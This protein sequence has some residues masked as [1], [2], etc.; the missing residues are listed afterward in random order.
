MADR[1]TQL[2]DALD[3]QLTMMYAALNYI[4]TRQPYSDIPGQ[5]NLAPDPAPIPTPDSV[6]APQSAVSQLTNGDASQQQPNGPSQPSQQAVVEEPAADGRPRTPP[7][8]RPE[9][10]NRA[11]REMAQGLVL[12]EQ[13]IEYLINS[14]PGLGNSEESQ[15][16][17][18]RELEAELREVEAERARAEAEKERMVDMLGEVIGKVK[19]I[20]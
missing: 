4:Q 12:Q 7:P 15:V 20:P 14:L 13:Q 9:V 3:N 18:M 5:P 8:E 11:M 19:R 2:Q 1:L 17:R 10:F 16:R 6:L